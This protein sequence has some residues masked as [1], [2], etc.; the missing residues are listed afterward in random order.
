LG[1]GNTDTFGAVILMT[2]KG[3]VL[4]AKEGTR[5]YREKKGKWGGNRL[6]P[7]PRRIGVGKRGFSLREGGGGRPATAPEG[8]I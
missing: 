3:D 6:V 8:V 5:V 1:N 4:T 2:V 7:V